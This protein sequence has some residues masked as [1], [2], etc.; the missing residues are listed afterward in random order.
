MELHRLREP[1]GERSTVSADSIIGSD[2][3]MGDR[4]SLKKSI[5]G[6]H[7]S[8]GNNVK[9]TNSII[10]DHVTIADGCQ[11]AGSVVCENCH[12]QSRLGIRRSSRVRI[13]SSADKTCFSWVTIGVH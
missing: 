10:M 2:V 1:F 11:V 12:I 9:I 4:S 5:V 13:L 3:R 7:C 6:D 8:I